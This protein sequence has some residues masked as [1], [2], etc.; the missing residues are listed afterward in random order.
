MV[1]PLP[2][3]YRVKL[4]VKSEV[5]EQTQMMCCQQKYLIGW[6]SPLNYS[7][8]LENSEVLGQTPDVNK[9]T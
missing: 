9:N 4:E 8:E 2:W 1:G 5:L 7:G 3:N 6:S